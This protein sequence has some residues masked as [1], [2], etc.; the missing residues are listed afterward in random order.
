MWTLFCST[1]LTSAGWVQLTIMPRHCPPKTKQCG[2]HWILARRFLFRAENQTRAG[3]MRSANATSVLCRPP[4]KCEH[5]CSTALSSTGWVRSTIKRLALST[6]TKQ[7]WL[8]MNLA[9]TSRKKILG[10][11]LAEN[12]TRGG[13]QVCYPLCYSDPPFN[14]F[15]THI[16]ISTCYG[17]KWQ[18]HVL[19]RALMSGWYAQKQLQFPPSHLVRF[20]Q[21]L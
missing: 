17:I 4:F 21:K 18:Y 8:S 10:N 11:A 13:K 7:C 3:G 9:A 5:F 1:A 12:R 16:L 14:F 2:G 20:W 15:L 19:F 6:N